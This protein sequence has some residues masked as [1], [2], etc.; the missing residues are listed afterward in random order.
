[1]VLQVV[2]H[3]RD[4]VEALKLQGARLGVRAFCD[5]LWAR[6]S[7]AAIGESTVTIDVGHPGAPREC[8]APRLFLPRPC[9]PPAGPW[10]GFARA[11]APGNQNWEGVC[12]HEAIRSEG[13]LVTFNLGDMSRVSV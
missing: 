11:S 2:D 9:L 10:L 13:I 1:M 6:V 8:C 3:V 5:A 7:A 12:H 4:V